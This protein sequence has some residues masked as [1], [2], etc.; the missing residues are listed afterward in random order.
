MGAEGPQR[1]SR[2]RLISLTARYFLPA[3]WTAYGA[4]A[5]A[6]ERVGR[7]KIPPHPVPGQHGHAD[8]VDKGD[9]GKSWRLSPCSSGPDIRGENHGPYTPLPGCYSQLHPLV[10]PQVLHFMH[11]PLRTKV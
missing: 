2:S 1:V 9:D 3:A 5:P 11:V 8:R 4:S 10:A 7:S 6:P